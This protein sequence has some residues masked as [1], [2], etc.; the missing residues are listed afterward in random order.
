MG[1][2]AVTL[3]PATFYSG[4]NSSPSF[5]PPPTR[6]PPRLGFEAPSAYSS[7]TPSLVDALVKL[8]GSVT[9]INSQ[10]A[11]QANVD[12]S[13]E[14]KLTRITHPLDPVNKG[15]PGKGPSH[16]GP[17]PPPP[18]CNYCGKIGHSVSGCFAKRDA[19]MAASP[20]TH[21]TYV[22]TATA[23]ESSP[24][25]YEAFMTIHDDTKAASE[26]SSL[27]ILSESPDLPS[28]LD[29]PSYGY[30]F[31]DPST[32]VRYLGLCRGAN[33]QI[34]RSLID[35]G[36][37]I[38]NVYLCDKDPLA[39]RMVL[40]TLQQLVDEYPSNFSDYLRKDIISGHIFN[41][42]PQDVTLSDSTS[43]ITLSGVNLG[44][45]N[46]NYQLL[47]SAGK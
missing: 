35:K 41:H 34:L 14:D 39:R 36:H 32:A 28:L 25:H 6:T 33:T 24:I 38:A 19:D 8:T 12:K 17:R 18:T 42:I 31:S 40:A 30:H 37:F 45:A 5:L 21:A 13:F 47:S 11:S 15:P 2:I 3:A 23:P 46:P 20:K 16:G 1:G 10:L 44:I 22:A 43:I 26:P 29:I 9:L 7:P 4:S 27:P